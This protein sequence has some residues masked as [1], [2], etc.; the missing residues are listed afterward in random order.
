M[1]LQRQCIDVVENVTC[2][3]ELTQAKPFRQQ[4]ADVGIGYV[5]RALSVEIWSAGERSVGADLKVREVPQYL[6]VLLVD[7]EGVL[8]AFDGLIIVQVR[9]VDQAASKR[10]PLAYTPRDSRCNVAAADDLVVKL[11]LRMQ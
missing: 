6:V 10:L 3:P 4:I 9:P 11:A 8:V 7:A 5:K 2:T 1:Q